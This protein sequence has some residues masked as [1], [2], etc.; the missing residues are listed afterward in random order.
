VY[1]PERAETVVLSLLPS[2]R[3]QKVSETWR[4]IDLKLG[5][6]VRGQLIL[7]LLVATVLSMTFW[8]IGM[9]YWLL[10]GVFAGIVEL[11]PVLGPLAAGTLAVAVGITASWHTAVA[12]GLAVLAVRLLEDYLVMP[13]LL[14]NAVGLSPLVILTAVSAAGILLG[15]F[16]V[17][18]AIPLAA[19]VMT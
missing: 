6:F 13:R 8:A 7:T 16:A 15:G 12:A 4:L 2:R 18:L 10:L 11:I 14:G 9:P 19:L 5:A 1:E 17:L 3:R